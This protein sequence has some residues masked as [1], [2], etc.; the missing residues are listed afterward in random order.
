MPVKAHWAVGKVKQAHS[1]LR[2]T[3]DILRAE[4][5]SSTDDE[6]VLQIA[7]KALN[8]TAGPN[9]LVPTLLVF[10]TYPCINA[11]SPPSLDIL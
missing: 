7:L 3:F 8:D 5:K 11:D 2:R 4:L 6:D 1:P 9:G 10:G